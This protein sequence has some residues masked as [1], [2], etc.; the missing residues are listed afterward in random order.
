MTNTITREGA[1]SKGAADD[2]I[3]I[4]CFNNKRY[5]EPCLDSLYDAKLRS[6]FEVI[7]VD[8]GSTDGSQAMLRERF[9]EVT[10]IQNPANLGLSR[11]CNQGMEVS[12][13]R[14]V[15]LLNDD[16]L[17][18]GPS[19]D[20][21]V[22]FLDEH[23]KAAAVGGRLLNPDGSLQAGHSRF[24]TL[25]EEFLIAS[26]LAA[27][28][29]TEKVLSRADVNEP[30]PVDW[31]GSACLLLR[32]EAMQQVGVLDE[33]YFI[34]GDEADLQYRFHR[35]GWLVYYL[36]DV[37]TIHFGG[38]SMDR[39]RRRKMVYRGKMLFYKKNYGA[40]RAALLRI[41]L[42]AMSVGKMVIWVAGLALPKWRLR[43]Q[44]ELRSNA[45]VVKLCV[46]LA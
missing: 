13:G 40:F 24:S 22:D 15:L 38:R 45:D 14:Y 3:V 29:G 36:P 7:A 11:A 17:V 34:Y 33:E 8:N 18:N 27:F 9:P 12:K 41:M 46:K 42:G 5:L 16:T 43:A 23:P 10:I 28:F 39:W 31:L 32:P 44:R 35:H 21:M 6:T 4:V 26:G 30:R 19:F 37:T 25:L 2:S 1:G 20:A